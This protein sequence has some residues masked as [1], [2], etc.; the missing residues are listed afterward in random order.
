MKFDTGTTQ[1]ALPAVVRYQRNPGFNQPIVT[2]TYHYSSHN[3]FGYGESFR[4]TP[5]EDGKL[6]NRLTSY[7]YSSV[8]TQEGDASKKIPA[9]RIERCYN[10]LHLLVS[11]TEHEVGSALIVRREMQY[12]AV[13]GDSFNAQ[14]SACRLPGMQKVTWSDGAG[15]QRSEITNFEYDPFGNLARQTAH[16]GSVTIYEYYP[17]HA[18]PNCP[19]EPNG[20]TRFIKSRTVVP[21]KNTD[22]GDVPSLK[23]EWTYQK[24]D[25]REGSS[26]TWAVM[27]L[28]ITHFANETSLSTEIFTYTVDNPHSNEYGRIKSHTTVV[29]NKESNYSSVQ[30]FRFVLDKYQVDRA[31]AKTLTQHLTTTVDAKPG[32]KGGTKKLVVTT[33]NTQ[34]A[35][36]GRLLADIDSFRNQIAYEYDAA[37]RLTSQKTH[38]DKPA[39]FVEETW[40]YLPPSA[41]GK[42]PSQVEHKNRFGQLAR[43]SLDGLGRVM[44]EESKDSDGA[45]GWRTVRIEGYDCLG[46]NERSVSIDFLR[47]SAQTGEAQELRSTVLRQWD[48]WG[49]LRGQVGQENQLTEYRVTDPIALTETSWIENQGKFKTGK[50]V[51]CLKP[52]DRLPNKTLLL[53]YDVHKQAWDPETSPYSVTQQAWDGANQLREVTDENNH[54]TRYDYDAYGRVTHTTLPDGTVIRHQYAPFSSVSLVTQI[55]VQAKG[56]KAPVVLGVQEFD[57]FGRLTKTTSGGRTSLFTYVSDAALQPG[58][59][60]QP[61][62]ARIVCTADTQLNEVPTAIV[63]TGAHGAIS[64]SFSYF[65]QTGQIKSAAEGNSCISD[66]TTYPSG[67][68]K[69]ETQ[70]ILSGGQHQAGY[71]YSLGGALQQRTGVDGVVQKLEYSTSPATTG[72]IIKLSESGVT[73]DLQY[74]AFQ[75]LEHWAT[76]DGVGNRLTT[77][78]ELDSFGR[79]IRRTFTHSSGDSRTLTQAWYPNGQLRRR[80]LTH[81]GQQMCTETFEYDERDRLVKYTASGEQ[82]PVDAYGNEFTGQIFVFDVLDNIIE[83]RTTLKSGETNIALRRFDNKDPCQLSGVSNSLTTH[84]Y[85]AKVRLAYDAAGRLTRDGASH[86]FS[87]DALGRLSAVDGNEGKSDYG[88]DVAGR[89]A[90]QRIGQDSSLHRLYYEREGLASEWVSKGNQKQDIAK[91]YIIQPVYVAGNSVARRETKAGKLTTELVSVDEKNRIL[92]TAVGSKTETYSYTPDGYGTPIPLTRKS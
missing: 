8:E 64:Q 43:V 5:P 44:R 62:G 79:E 84:G 14:P 13:T 78:R 16:D 46:R 81:N 69:A 1:G 10:N 11:E 89:M 20:F 2:S 59:I 75:Q 91:D 34:S 57:G 90:W 60:I 65:Q 52:R 24:V 30:T 88:Y 51:V 15:N 25:A 70:D 55:S 19:A 21:Y 12:G 17:A 32:D 22:Y 63:A 48:A 49:M 4:E 29:H 92:S 9:R 58:E 31:V 3:Y 36:T 80:V 68:L 42:V 27:P 71:V 82:L 87:Y 26:L 18:T 28:Q 74:G 77:V 6:Y 54:V 41:D 40:T 86:T 53:A 85:P 47:Q 66:W 33:S 23:T 35:Y 67:R 76:S 38:P 56:S 83:C 73:T 39:Y 72:Q 61:D 45:L 7:Q 37:G 50:R